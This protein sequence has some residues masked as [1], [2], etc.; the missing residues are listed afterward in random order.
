MTSAIKFNEGSGFVYTIEDSNIP[1]MFAGVSRLL[2]QSSSFRRLLA[3]V[4][5]G[6]TQEIILMITQNPSGIPLPNIDFSLQISEQDL[7]KTLLLAGMG[8]DTSDGTIKLQD[9]WKNNPNR[10][11]NAWNLLDVNFDMNKLVPLFNK[12]R[13]SMEMM[14]KE[15]GEKGSAS[16]LHHYG[17]LLTQMKT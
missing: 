7:S 16:F 11:M 15:I 4:G 9:A 10:D 14:A 13:H 2:S 12:M 1:K 8:T 5:S 3:N 17:I 6:R